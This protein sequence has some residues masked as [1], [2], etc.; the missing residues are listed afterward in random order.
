MSLAASRALSIQE[1]THQAIEY[2]S[3]LPPKAPVDNLELEGSLADVEV[4]AL[5]RRET[6]LE[7]A[8]GRLP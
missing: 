6:E 4:E 8:K 5:M 7:L 3:A 2:W 1:A